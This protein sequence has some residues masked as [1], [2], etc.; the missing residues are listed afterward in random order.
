MSDMTHP[1]IY[2]KPFDDDPDEG[3]WGSEFDNLAEMVGAVAYVPQSEVDRLRA[4]AKLGMAVMGGWPDSFG[5]IDGFDL[6]DMA[7]KS[8]V[9]VRV[10]GGF[11]PNVHD[12]S[13]DVEPGDD[14]FTIIPKAPA[15]TDRSAP[16]TCEGETMTDKPDITPENVARMLDGV[17]PGPW[18]VCIDDDGNP[19]SGR[20]SVQAPE[21]CDCAIVHWDGFVQNYWRSARGDKEI[22]ANA[23]FI[24]YAREA[25]PALAARVAELEKYEAGWAEAEGRLTDAE[26]KLAE[27]DA[28][29]ARREQAAYVEGLAN[30]IAM[31]REMRATDGL[32]TGQGLIVAGLEINLAK[33]RAALQEKQP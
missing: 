32:L 14:W 22:H 30:S 27:R 2:A 16:A 3:W 29:V 15:M 20:P 9:L 12:W 5:D 7:E 33:A 28:E 21:D 8:G 25:V 17:T 31:V 4:W 1:I 19:L 13:D 11:N 6:Q 10:P 26:A 24:A 18:S 23:R